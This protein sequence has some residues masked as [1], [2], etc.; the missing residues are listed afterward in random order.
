MVFE[1]DLLL[2][3]LFNDAFFTVYSWFVI[4]SRFIVNLVQPFAPGNCLFFEFK[5]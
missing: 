4:I 5:K 2:M 1:A 3:I